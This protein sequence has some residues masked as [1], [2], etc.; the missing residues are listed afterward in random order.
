MKHVGLMGRVAVSFCISTILPLILMYLMFMGY[1]TMSMN[2]VTLI[3]AGLFFIG[4]IYMGIVKPVDELKA[5]A[6]RI[7]SGDL[8]FTLEA[9]TNDEFG[10]LMQA[11]DEMR[12]RLKETQDEK[13]RNDN[14]N[15]ELITNIAHD[16]KTPLTA[17]KGYSEGILD[18]IAQS[19]EM[20]K[21][22]I[23]TINIKANDMDRL[24]DELR[25][26]VKVES[27]KIPY[28]FQHM[29]VQDYFQDCA[30]EIGLDMES[31]GID[32]T[33]ENSIDK[34][35]EMIADPE[36][37]RKVINNIISNSVKYMDKD[38]RKIALTLEDAGDFI[39]VNITDNGKGI[40]K[41]DLPYIFQRFFRAD[42]SRNSMKGGS[43]I[44][45]SIVKKIVEDSGGRIWASSVEGDGTTI[46]FVLRKYIRS[47]QEVLIDG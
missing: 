20:Q 4:W 19:P 17:I 5:A 25:Y 30:D 36:Q 13:I 42:S 24:I 40:A 23:Q 38:Y 37:L 3:V 31:Q 8:D 27:N 26:Y 6:R 32:F 35:V 43:G 16:L 44:G 12:M 46:H 41:T 34:D 11:F 45:L 15:R 21:K 33:F 9:E 39:Q 22:Y 28:D 7:E 29:R 14:A 47:V 1:T 2:V 18:G 10:E